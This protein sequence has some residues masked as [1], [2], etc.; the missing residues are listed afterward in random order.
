MV[1][2]II[3]LVTIVQS[4]Y[5]V[6]AVANYN[7]HEVLYN[8]STSGLGST[9]VNGAIEELYEASSNYSSLEARITNLQE[10]KAPLAN[11]SLTGVVKAPTT[12]AGTNTTQIATTSFVNTAI[13]NKKNGLGTIYYWSDTCEGDDEC[14]LVGKKIT[15]AGKYILFASAQFSDN[16]TTGYRGIYLTST[17]STLNDDLSKYCRIRERTAQSGYTILSFAC[18]VT[19]PEPLSI[20]Y[21]TEDDYSGNFTK[22]DARLYAL[23]IA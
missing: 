5:V 20:S 15:S 17:N 10:N 6:Y 3:I 7:A 9:N 22:I 13:T 2:S 23:K 19:V 11:P 12:T 16:S 1:L 14:D 21:W 4:L 8:N 18:V